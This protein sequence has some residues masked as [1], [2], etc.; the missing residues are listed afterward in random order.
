MEFERAVQAALAA[1]ESGDLVGGAAFLEPLLRHEDPRRAAEARLHLGRIMWKQG[2]LDEALR[3]CREVSGQALR[4][5]ADDLRAQADNALGVLYTTRSEYVQAK[6]SYQSA[7]ERTRDPVTRAKIILNLGVIAN[8]E[9]KLDLARQRYEQARGLFK[10][11]GDDRDEAL[12]LLNTGMLHSDTGAWD[13]ADD[14]LGRALELFEGHRNRAMIANVLV[15]Q[16]EVACGRGHPEEAIRLCDLALQTYAELGNEP[17]RCEALKWKGHALRLLGE[18]PAAEEVL[19][20]VL[21]TAKRLRFKLLEAETARELGGSLTAR[22][23]AAAG[24][25]ALERA[26]RLFE[27]LGAERDAEAVRGELGGPPAV[28]T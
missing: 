26:L 15:N 11:A 9:G 5:G 25:R 16:S 7:L 3:L 20:E 10:Q 18:G 21:R 17:G 13:E 19:G 14:A 28:Q 12:A 22:G 27:A 8:I 23:E 1:E 24:R 4:L 6:A 2:R